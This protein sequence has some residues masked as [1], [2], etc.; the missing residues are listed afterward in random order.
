MGLRDGAWETNVCA[1]VPGTMQRHRWGSV[2][3][4]SGVEREGG[5]VACRAGPTLVLATS[6]FLFWACVGG[7][8]WRRL[9][10]PAAVGISF[11]L[12]LTH[13]RTGGGSSRVRAAACAS[14]V[15]PS[16]PPSRPVPAAGRG[17][18]GAGKRVALHVSRR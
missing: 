10:C 17:P 8:A 5:G 11:S 12:Y 3:T 4:C 13:V 16:G 9:P 7:W 15:S 14:P 2:Q 1:N 6:P 18:S